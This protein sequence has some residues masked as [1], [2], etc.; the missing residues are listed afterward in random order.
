MPPASRARYNLADMLG[1]VRVNV[2]R[3]VMAA[4]LA[5]IVTAGA[6]PSAR[7]DAATP[8]A[9]PPQPAAASSRPLVDQVLR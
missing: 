2:F 3:V 5:A 6:A 4:G 9:V 1:K 7:I 8:Q